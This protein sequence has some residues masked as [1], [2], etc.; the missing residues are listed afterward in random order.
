MIPVYTYKNQKVTVALSEGGQFT[1][2]VEFYSPSS[3]IPSSPGAI[4]V[5]VSDLHPRGGITAHGYISV[6]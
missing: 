1:W 5:H 3:A 6:P 4:D 2:S